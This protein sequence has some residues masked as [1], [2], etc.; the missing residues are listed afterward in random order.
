MVG[1]LF[2]PTIVPERFSE[3]VSG[4]AWIGA[5]LVWRNA[6]DMALPEID[7]SRRPRV[8]SSGQWKAST[9]TTVVRTHDSARFSP[10]G[11]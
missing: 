5:M 9:R 11:R 3:A 10:R 4:R 6:L 8:G 1:D 7:G 2:R